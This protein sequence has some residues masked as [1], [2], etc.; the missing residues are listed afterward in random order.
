ML[1]THFV[2]LTAAAIAPIAAA[3]EPILVDL[4][5]RTERKWSILLPE[6][7]FQ[8]VSGSF[9]LNGQHFAVLLDG[10]S[11]AVDTDG[12]GETDRRVRGT[13]DDSGV[14]T[15][16]VTLSGTDG[17][18]AVRLRDDGRGWQWSSAGMRRG[19][20]GDTQVTIIDQDLDG[21][22]DG[23]GVDA[24]IV[25]RRSVASYLSRTI[26]VNGELLA[27]DV[28]PD[29][30]T[31]TAVAFNDAVGQ[32]DMSTGLN[33]DARL[34][35]AIVRST[36]KAHSFDMAASRG[37]MRVPAGT[38]EI[39]GG[40]LGLGKQRVQV[41][42]GRADLIEVPADGEASVAWGGPVNAEFAYGRA[43]N[44][45]QFSPDYIWYFG[46]AGE[47]YHGWHPIGESPEFTV[48]DAST[49]EVLAVAILPGST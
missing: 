40:H 49:G 19:A 22:Y 15:A 6:E 42:R 7:K 3:A 35:G 14:R 26:N 45:V 23:Y 33:T 48:E 43:G 25:G 9:E 10:T 11:L 37:A 34:I 1:R 32:L 24:M 28:A 12:D 38:Y 17:K 18:Y 8:P 16:R 20:I 5:Y 29:G 27:I 13:E 39:I 4:D 31:L 46:A 21:R 36:D 44:Q 41:R 30:S 47:E 2:A